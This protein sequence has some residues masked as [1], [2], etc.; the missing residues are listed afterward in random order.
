MTSSVVT[1]GTTSLRTR[2]ELHASWCSMKLSTLQPHAH[3]HPL[4]QTTAISA[5]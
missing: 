4:N 1:T 5:H 3:N 2:P